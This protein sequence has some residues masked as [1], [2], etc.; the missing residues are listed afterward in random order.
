[1]TYRS[2]PISFGISQYHPSACNTAQEG[3]QAGGQVPAEKSGFHVRAINKL[4]ARAVATLGAGK[5]ADG[6]G[7]WLHKRTDGGGQWVLR[8]TV[9]GRRREMGLGSTSNVTL[10]EARDA[11]DR[12]RSMVRSNAEAPEKIMIEI[13]L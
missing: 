5:Y 3:G 10:K 6:A 1:M 8:V 13:E 4:N 7:L 11:A 12:A 9:H 2:V